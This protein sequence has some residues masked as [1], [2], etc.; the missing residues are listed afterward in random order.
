MN[1]VAHNLSHDL[2]ARLQGLDLFFYPG[3]TNIAALLADDQRRK[4]V[5]A[6]CVQD[7]PQFNH[8]EPLWFQSAP[9]LCEKRWEYAI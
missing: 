4:R 6:C 3:P 8:T 7:S 5:W 9:K 2:D 1:H